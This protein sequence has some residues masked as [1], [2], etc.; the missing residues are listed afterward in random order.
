MFE[1]KVDKNF[2]LDYEK[3]VLIVIDMVKGFTDIGILRSD[4][5]KNIAKDI[6]KFCYKFPNVI[7]IN[8]NHKN[9]DCEFD[10]YPK[11][12]LEGDFE[13][14]LCEELLD[15]EFKHVLTKNST[16]SFFSNNFIQIFQKYIDDNFNF[17]VV[18]CCTDICILQFC[19]TFKGYL[20]S[21]N[22]NLNIIV[23]K[24]LVE[25]YDRENHPRDKVQNV[26]LYFMDNM[27]IKL[28]ESEI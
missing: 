4:F 9:E 2:N 17:V 26:S 12:C 1:I 23:P 28:I 10:V 5:I 21:I 20:N 6:K 15:I 13:S 19:L 24:D 11:H 3:S 8:D 22:K 7:A 27:G 14:E 16:N 25:T 18:G